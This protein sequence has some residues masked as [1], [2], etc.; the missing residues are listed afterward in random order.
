MSPLPPAPC[1]S[2]Q[3][4][5]AFSARPHEYK[6]I[7]IQYQPRYLFSNPSE[8]K[9]IQEVLPMM[10]EVDIL[11]AGSTRKKTSTDLVVTDK[12][13]KVTKKEPPKVYARFF[14]K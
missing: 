12:D 1:A 7:T 10:N 4:A 5:P 2:F 6:V 3:A 11:E 13:G 8:F 14:A 9:I